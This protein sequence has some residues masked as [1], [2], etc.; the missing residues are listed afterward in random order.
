MKGKKTT[1]AKNYHSITSD[2]MLTRR[3]LRTRALLAL[4]TFFQSDTDRI[5]V[6]EKQMMQ[7]IDK[8]YDLFIYQLSFIAEVVNFAEIRSEESKTKFF[9]TPNDINPNTKFINNRFVKQLESNSDFRKNFDR[10]KINWSA[11]QE[12][13]R[14]MYQIF[15]ES[16]T[17]SEFM[18]SPKDSYENDKEIIV[19]FVKKFLLDF[20]SLKFYFEEKSIYWVDDYYTVIQFIVKFINSWKESYDDFKPLPELFKDDSMS[21]ADEDKQFLKDL[22]RKTIINSKK[23]E[24]L[25]T[26]KAK[27]WELDRIASMDILI[28]KMA[29]V[30]ILEFPSIPPKVTL[31][32]YIDLAKMFSSPKSNIFVNGI[33]DKLILD[34]KNQNMIKKAGR[35]LM[36]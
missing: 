3:H 27:N 21:K 10:L 4:Y 35:G 16:D 14:K 34:L 17:Y 5:D 33:L 28:I 29:L 18:E 11:E 13:V 26:E 6:V 20:N 7:N 2:F 19:L 15:I 22:L 30:E 36:E 12:M 25:I 31:N 32:E 8:L 1:F 9:P 23:Y 24:Q